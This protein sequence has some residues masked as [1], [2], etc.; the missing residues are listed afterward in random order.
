MKS[1][2]NDIALTTS[3]MA[4][5]RSLHKDI[6]LATTGR[7]NK[8]QRTLAKHSLNW[9][10]SSGK[11]H[12]PVMYACPSEEVNVNFEETLRS[13]DNAGMSPHV[14]NIFLCNVATLKSAGVDF[15]DQIIS[16][17]L[18]NDKLGGLL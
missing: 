12:A 17:F 9:S 6:S 15:A 16:R 7:R 2:P 8:S 14:I 3:D 11:S 4:I 18:D 5:R 10:N 13:L 1:M